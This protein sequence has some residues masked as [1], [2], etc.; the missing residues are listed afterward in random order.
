MN[1]TSFVFIYV[2][3]EFDLKFELQNTLNKNLQDI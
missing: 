2:F 3:N 1:T